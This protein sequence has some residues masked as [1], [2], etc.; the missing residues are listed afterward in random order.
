MVEGIAGHQAGAEVRRA[1]GLHA[2]PDALLLA[3]LQVEGEYQLPVLDPAPVK[4]TLVA[5]AVDAFAVQA[6]G[7]ELIQQGIADQ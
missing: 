2:Q 7:V 5:R 1:I 4:G 6:V 3:G